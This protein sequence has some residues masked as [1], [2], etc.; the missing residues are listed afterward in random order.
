MRIACQVCRE[1]SEEQRLRDVV[2][3]DEPDAS[4]AQLLPRRLALVTDADLKR[5]HWVS[6]PARTESLLEDL[7]YPLPWKRKKTK[8][9]IGQ[10]HLAVFED[11]PSKRQRK[12]GVILSLVIW[13]FT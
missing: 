12:P 11:E 13:S 10:V 7:M 9:G 6:L 2:D 4:A 3:A 5:M 8:Q 1:T